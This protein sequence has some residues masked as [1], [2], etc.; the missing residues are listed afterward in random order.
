MR[1]TYNPTICMYGEVTP[2]GHGIDWSKTPNNPNKMH[3]VHG[4]TV[5]LRRGCG[6][7][8]R[9][10]I[11][12]GQ[13]LRYNSPTNGFFTTAGV[14]HSAKLA[15]V[16]TGLIVLSEGNQLVLAGNMHEEVD[17]P[18]TQEILNRMMRARAQAVA[19]TLANDTVENNK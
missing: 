13:S 3:E 19:G 16:Q 9:E 14:L 5:R 7:N 17:R 2:V 8:T 4:C 11:I 6:R 18:H 12:T 15:E 10:F 1:T